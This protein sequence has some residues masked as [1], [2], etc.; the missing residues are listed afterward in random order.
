ME[1]NSDN[2][3][4]VSLDHTI[5]QLVYEIMEESSKHA[6]NKTL[7]EIWYSDYYTLKRNRISSSIVILIDCVLVDIAKYSS[8][9]PIELYEHIE[10]ASGQGYWL[11]YYDCYHLYIKCN[12]YCI[13]YEKYW[14]S[15]KKGVRSN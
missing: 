6:P 10:W 7:R 12:E 4:A 14:K 2:L 9:I 3:L 13:A 15:K 1:I 5:H 11:G 8:H